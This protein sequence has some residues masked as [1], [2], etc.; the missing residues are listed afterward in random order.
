MIRPIAPHTQDILEE[1]LLLTNGDRAQDYGDMQ[2]SF[3]RIAALWSPILGVPV[4]AKHVALCMIQL[5][6][7]RACTSDKRDNW[8]DI[9]EVSHGGTPLAPLTGSHSES[10][11]PRTK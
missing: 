10:N 8:V 5:K 6:V 4:T 9:A 3:E 1:A 2:A 11:D 7:S